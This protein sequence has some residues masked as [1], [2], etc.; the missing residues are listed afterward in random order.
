MITQEFQQSLT[1]TSLHHF[2]SLYLAVSPHSVPGFQCLPDATLTLQPHRDNALHGQQSNEDYR[3]T[4]RGTPDRIQKR[5]RGSP[6]TAITDRPGVRREWHRNA[7]RR[8]VTFRH[9]DVSSLQR[10]PRRRH[11]YATGRARFLEWLRSGSFALMGRSSSSSSASFLLLL[12]HA[13]WRG[14]M[15]QGTGISEANMMVVHDR[16]WADDRNIARPASIPGPST[17]TCRLIR[18]ST[19]NI[20]P[21]RHY[22]T[23]YGARRHHEQT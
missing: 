9:T 2:G 4:A 1:D 16:S 10:F 14:R 15:T 19:E 21:V 13:A 18:H 11:I 8:R 23:N 22:R 12:E 5:R 17:A 3:T 20:P 7:D 6:A